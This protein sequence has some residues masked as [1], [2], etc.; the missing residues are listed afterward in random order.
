MKLNFQEGDTL[1]HKKDAA[2]FLVRQDN[3]TEGPLAKLDKTFKGALKEAK[4]EGLVKGALG[5]TLTLPTYGQFKSKKIILLGLG[6]TIKDR[7]DYYV[8][9]HAMTL[10]MKKS[11]AHTACLNL[12]VSFDNAREFLLGASSTL[13]VLLPPPTIRPLLAP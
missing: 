9:G 1:N 12:N 8:A 3:V 11:K 13:P 10:A 5:S 4:K 2:V 7:R 6:K